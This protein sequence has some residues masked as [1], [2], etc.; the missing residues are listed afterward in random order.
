[1]AAAVSAAPRCWWATSIRVSISRVPSTRPRAR[2]EVLLCCACA[3]SDVEVEIESGAALREGSL[4][5]YEATVDVLEPMAHDVRRLVLRLPAGQ[6]IRFE[7]GQYIN[8]LLDD[9]ARR[10][11]SFTTPSG[12]TDQIELHV[13]RIPGGRFTT[14]VFERLQ[15]GDRLRFEGPLGEFV[16]REP[17]ERPLIFVAG[18]TGFAP[19]KSLLEQA[20]AM[21][22][23]RPL[24]FYWGVRRPHDFYM[25]DMLQRWT[26]AH[27]NFK[28]VPVVSDAQPED[29]WVGRTGLVHQAI[30][31]DFADLS[32]YSVYA[33]GSVAMVQAAQP[34]L[35]EHGLAADQCF[36]D[37]FFAAAPGAKQEA[38]A[39]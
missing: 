37:A 6:T 18:A 33:C 8:I 1:M 29:G 39:A 2:G 17:S 13:R 11:Y 35:V 26:L 28:F 19:V 12:E 21:K 25:L 22:L 36:S 16:L 10:S 5:V 23:T 9:D 27:P 7:A 34:A 15:R 14:Q 31:A 32:D 3:T 20:F 4:P 30:L 38:P 24:H